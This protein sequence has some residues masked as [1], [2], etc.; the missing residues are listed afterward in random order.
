MSSSKGFRT[1]MLKMVRCEVEREYEELW[2]E[3]NKELTTEPFL[4]KKYQVKAKTT[5]SMSP[6]FKIVVKTK[7]AEVAEALKAIELYGSKSQEEEA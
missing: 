3:Y 2:K 4:P 7:E 1:L 5:L 6:E